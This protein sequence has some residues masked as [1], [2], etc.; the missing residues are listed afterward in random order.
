MDDFNEC[1]QCGLGFREYGLSYLGIQIDRQKRKYKRWSKASNEIA[2]FLNFIYARFGA[3]IL[4]MVKVQ[5]YR[6]LS[7][8]CTLK[9]YKKL[10]WTVLYFSYLL[11]RLCSHLIA[12]AS[13]QLICAIL[14]N[15]YLQADLGFRE[16]GVSYLG[17]RFCFSDEQYH[18]RVPDIKAAC[19]NRT[20]ESAAY[21]H[22]SGSIFKHPWFH[23]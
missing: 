1:S 17:F 23:F 2:Y 22:H 11:A 8:R 12:F 10:H 21:T 7:F 19:D 5:D 4:Q 18:R 14:F 20:T 6:K 9:D 3:R 15:Q 16:Y 13:V